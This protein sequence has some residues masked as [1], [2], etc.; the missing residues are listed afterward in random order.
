LHSRCGELL[1]WDGV[2]RLVH[3]STAK[4]LAVLPLD[5]IHMGS[6]DDHRAAAVAD[7]DAVLGSTSDADDGEP[8]TPGRKRWD[9]LHG[10]LS[11]A[12]AFRSATYV[13][14]EGG[15]LLTALVSEPYAKERLHETL[16]E[17]EPQY[18]VADDANTIHAGTY[19]F[20]RHVASGTYLHLAAEED[21]HELKA[22]LAPIDAE[23]PGP[24]A[25][26]PTYQRLA[27]TPSSARLLVATPKRYDFDVFGTTLVE[28][29]YLRDMIFVTSCAQR[30]RAYLDAFATAKTK[31]D[32]SFNDVQRVLSELIVFVTAETDNLDPLTRRGLPRT[33]QQVPLTLPLTPT[34]VALRSSSPITPLR[35][36]TVCICAGPR[37]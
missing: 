1:A 27:A 36:R 13:A 21:M 28:S 15:T 14:D 22:L 30:I 29:Q 9:Q 3:T 16:F 2:V 7:A 37:M 11:A 18:D 34:S 33:A 12:N 24:S 4:A 6:E 25:N 5:D 10:A 20:V 32:V 31:A 23:N 17:L 8:V 26:H 35:P 19:F